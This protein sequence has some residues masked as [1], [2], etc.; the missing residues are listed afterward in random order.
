M[1]IPHYSERFFKLVEDQSVYNDYEIDGKRD[2]H[3][4]FGYLR[5]PEIIRIL[6]GFLARP[7]ASSWS[8]R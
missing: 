5:I 2:P 8:D 6:E 1:A 3:K 7:P 4:C